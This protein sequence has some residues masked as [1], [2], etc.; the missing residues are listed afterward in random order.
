MQFCFTLF[1][2]VSASVLDEYNALNVCLEVYVSIVLWNVATIWCSWYSNPE[3]T[4][5]SLY[6][7]LKPEVSCT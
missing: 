7:G 6:H 5:V 4:S 1:W 3:D 2:S